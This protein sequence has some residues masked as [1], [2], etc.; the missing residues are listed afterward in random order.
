VCDRVL[1][2]RLVSVD[3][4]NG[5]NYTATEKN[6]L[7]FWL[8][9]INGGSVRTMIYNADADPGLNSF[10]TQVSGTFSVFERAVDGENAF[11][12]CLLV[13]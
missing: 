5:F 4:A 13:A 10:I 9:Q 1:V 12:R 11:C 2:S 8:R 6:V 7:P 3:N